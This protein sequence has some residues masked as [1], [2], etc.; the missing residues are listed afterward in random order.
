[1]FQGWARRN[2]PQAKVLRTVKMAA[3]HQGVVS[4]T[5]SLGNQAT[6]QSIET[7]SAKRQANLVKVECQTDL[8]PG[9]KSTADF[10]KRL[11][12]PI[13]SPQETSIEKPEEKKP[14]ISRQS[15]EWVEVP[16]RKRP[17]LETKRPE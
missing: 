17:R 6:S 1:M 11:R 5:V 9:V 15:E 10:R 16:A 12:E 2:N 7:R 8:E 13:V 14:K 4:F 3:W